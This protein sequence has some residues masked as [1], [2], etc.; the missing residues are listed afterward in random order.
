MKFISQVKVKTIDDIPGPKGLPLVGTALDYVVHRNGL[1][2][3]KM[4]EVCVE[5]LSEISEHRHFLCPRSF[6]F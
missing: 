4:F 2:F 5:K 3:D 6:L 1:S